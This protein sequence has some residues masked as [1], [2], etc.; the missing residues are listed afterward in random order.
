MKNRR[1]MDWNIL[2]CIGAVS[3]FSTTSHAAPT[4]VLHKATVRIKVFEQNFHLNALPP[5]SSFPENPY[6]LRTQIEIIQSKSIFYEVAN[7]LNLAEEWSADGKKLP[8]DAV[9]KILKK[10]LTVYLY[11]NTS[12][13]AISV[14][15]TDPVEAGKIANEI[16][17][18][19][20]DAQ[21]G[22]L[23]KERRASVTSF[24]KSMK[25]QRDRVEAAEKKVELL[26]PKFS[27]PGSDSVDVQNM[28]LARLEDARFS[29]W[30]EMIEIK[31]K[32]QILKDHAEEDLLGRAS[33]TCFDPM[34]L[35]RLQQI[36]DIKIQI[37]SLEA[38]QG[39][40]H[41][42]LKQSRLQKKKL[43]NTLAARLIVLE[44]SLKTEYTLSEKMFE[45]LNAEADS[46]PARGHQSPQ[47]RKALSGGDSRSGVGAVCFK[48]IESEN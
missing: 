5:D 31:A 30:K 24:E 19:F 6:F 13:I 2:L 37:T 1:I 26:Q 28:R 34:V 29:A 25:E 47:K 48:A 39:D 35:N 8:Q 12:L 16:A 17:N 7:R 40:E 14:Q 11:R 33:F 18:T 44:K 21:L 27:T 15:R 46:L 9:Y 42:E 23:E 45:T 3:F 32:L 20:R 41:P 36:Q 4:P 43:E 10:S 22:F 38:E